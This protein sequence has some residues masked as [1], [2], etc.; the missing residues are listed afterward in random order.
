MHTIQMEGERR[1][2]KS[3]ECSWRVME[4]AKWL[5]EKLSLKPC[6]VK[7]RVLK[8]LELWIMRGNVARFTFSSSM[9][10]GMQVREVDQAPGHPYAQGFCI[11]M[12]MRKCER[13]ADVQGSI[14]SW[15]WRHL[16]V[17]LVH[18]CPNRHTSREGCPAPYPHGFQ[19]S[20]T[21][22]WSLCKHFMKIPGQKHPYT[23]QA[24][25]T[26]V[27]YCAEMD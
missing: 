23:H 9:D 8:V 12:G 19:S 15:G 24:G 4:E 11:S 21:L 6:F 25:K 26:E 1:I 3:E 20:P 10:Q 27:W 7:I 16:W 2:I 14:S 13:D 18:C 17:L 22:L 5:K